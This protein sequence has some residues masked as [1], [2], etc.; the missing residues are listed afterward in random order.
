M[1]GRALFWFNSV[2]L[3]LNVR[4]NSVWLFIILNM[5]LILCAGPMI[6]LEPMRRCFGP[7]YSFHYNY[8]GVDTDCYII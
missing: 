2:N 4:S 6:I 5:S 7:Y 3:I 1:S 8:F